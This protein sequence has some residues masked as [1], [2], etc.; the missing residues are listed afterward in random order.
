MLRK[1]KPFR[2]NKHTLKLVGLALKM[3]ISIKSKKAT[4][5]FYLSISDITDKLLGYRKF[6]E[7]HNI[8]TDN[9]DYFACA[10]LVLYNHIYE[11][12][13]TKYNPQQ[14]VTKEQAE[15]VTKFRQ[16]LDNFSISSFEDFY[17]SIIN[18]E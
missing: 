7:K 14:Y 15:A 10:M 13:N 3:M 4:E 8:N 17:D 12:T 1:I 9:M 5:Y 2:R 18:N 16:S 11:S 6:I